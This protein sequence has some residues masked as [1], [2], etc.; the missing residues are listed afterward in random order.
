MPTQWEFNKVYLNTKIFARFKKEESAANGWAYATLQVWK[1]FT[2]HMEGFSKKVSFDTF[3]ES[4]IKKW[5]IY[6]RNKGLEEKSVQ[7]HFNN[8]R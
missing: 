4:G 1:T 8:L 3:N 7:K 2:N 6:L 5:V